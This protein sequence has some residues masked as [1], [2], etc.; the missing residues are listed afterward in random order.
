MTV[1]TVEPTN[2]R[3][4]V[5][6]IEK[7]DAG[8]K[9]DLNGPAS[10]AL[11]FTS[12]LLN[13]NVQ[14][15][16]INLFLS[17]L[18]QNE[19]VNADASNQGLTPKLATRENIS[20]AITY[21]FLGQGGHGKLLYLFWAG[22]GFITK[23]NSTTRRLFFT[24]TDT[25]NKWN[26]NFNSLLQDFQTS[27]RGTVFPQQIFFIDACANPIFRDF[28]PTIQAEKAEESFGTSGTQG[29]AE[30]FALFAA[31]EY[32][33]AKNKVTE[34]TGRFSKAVLEELQKQ[35]LQPDMH[36]V[37]RKIKQNF[38][39][40]QHQEPIFWDFSIGGGDREV[41]DNV[42]KKV[43]AWRLEQEVK[44]EN[45]AFLK[46]SASTQE[47]FKL[48]RTLNSLPAG[49]FEELV[50]TLN[51]SPGTISPSSAI[52]GIRSAELLY[53]IQGPTGPGVNELQAILGQVMKVPPPTPIMS[54]ES[55]VPEK[56]NLDIKLTAL[57]ELGLDQRN[58]LIDAL[59]SAYPNENF[60][61]L[62]L[63]RELGV[64]LN[65]IIQ[66]ARIYEETVDSLVEWAESNGKLK[67]LL[68]G[69]FQYN[70]GNPQL[71][72]LVQEW[73]S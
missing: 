24:D 25:N 21:D 59:V 28:Y 62:M 50:I 7:Y 52:R 6:G 42:E 38:R 14:P 23:I 35:P 10:D 34:G 18:A 40:K 48:I 26:L 12:W 16:A 64:K 8:D 49:E 31:A 55:P 58:N 54:F 19:L 45:H 57:P 65:S 17:P 53:W 66:N 13:R 30:Q 67:D 71:N 47:G 70:P 73:S 20:R 32:E 37:A 33:V 43:S 11:K 44:E 27:A 15:A 46:L 69:A 61:G 56:I 9:Y 51:P 39:D 1:S 5:V 2:V 22:H 3:A 41:I 4:L 29:Q 36:E 68:K 60:L 63:K 72:K